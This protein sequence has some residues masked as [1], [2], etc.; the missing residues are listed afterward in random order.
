MNTAMPSPAKAWVAATRPATLPLSLAPIVLGNALS[1]GHGLKA[2]IFFASLFTTL[3]LQIAANLINDLMDFKRGADQ[4][5]R[6][7]PPRAAAQGWLSPRALSFGA[8]G[9][10]LL[11]TAAGLPLVIHGGWPFAALG[12]LAI[13]AAAGYTAGP[14]PLAYLGLGDVFVFFFFGPVAVAGVALLQLQELPFLAW[15]ASN[16]I[17]CPATAVLVVNNLRRS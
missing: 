13:L 14:L 12:L 8:I 15:P 5:D 2:W 16:A 10:L 4:A 3:C 17:G 6:L 7:G 9:C 1:V 11:A